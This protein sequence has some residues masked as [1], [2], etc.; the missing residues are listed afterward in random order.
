MDAQIHGLTVAYTD[1]G[2]GTPV[3]FVHGFRSTETCG[4]PRSR[5]SPDST[6]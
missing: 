1:E 6:G 2:K 5:R 4:L 3:V